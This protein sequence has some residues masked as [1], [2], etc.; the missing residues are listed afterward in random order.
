MVESASL[1]WMLAKHKLQG[2]GADFGDAYGGGNR[3]ARWFT[4]GDLSDLKSAVG[5]MFHIS[6]TGEVS[7]SQIA[8]FDRTNSVCAHSTAETTYCDSALQV[9]ELV[10]LLPA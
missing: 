2:A 9:E 10:H 8:G 6:S 1:E 3:R 7:A 5:G 4:A